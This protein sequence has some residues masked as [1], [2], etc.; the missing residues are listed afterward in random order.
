MMNLPPL[1][2]TF[3]F[4]DLFA[5]FTQQVDNRVYQDEDKCILGSLRQRLVKVVVG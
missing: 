1:W 2:A 3:N 5:L 4:K